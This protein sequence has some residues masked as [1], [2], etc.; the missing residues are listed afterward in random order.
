MSNLRKFTD[1]YDKSGSKFPV[2]IEDIGKFEN[3]NNV[4][5]NL[6]AVEDRDIYIYRKSNYRRDREINLMLISKDDR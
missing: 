1:N 4:L 2:S 6:L 5:V 3:K